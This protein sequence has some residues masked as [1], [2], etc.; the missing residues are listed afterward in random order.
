MVNSLNLF[1]KKIYFQSCKTTGKTPII[2]YEIKEIYVVATRDLAKQFLGQDQTK[3]PTLLSM[4]SD[5]DW[6]I[7]HSTAPY[8]VRE[9]LDADQDLLI[10]RLTVSHGFTDGS[11]YEDY[12]YAILLKNNFAKSPRE[13]Q[14]KK[15]NWVINWQPN[16]IKSLQESLTIQWQKK[17]N[18]LVDKFGAVAVSEL[19]SGEVKEVK[20]LT[21]ERQ[22]TDSELASMTIEE[23]ISFL[24][25]WEPDSRDCLEE[26]SRQLLGSALAKLAEKNLQRYAQ[27]SAHFTDL[28]PIYLFNLLKGLRQGLNNQQGQQR[29][30]GQFSWKS[31][32]SLCS[33]LAQNSQTTD[34]DWRESCRAVLDLLELGLTDEQIGIPLQLREEVW[35]TIKLLNQA[36][37]PTPKISIHHPCELA[38]NTVNDQGEAMHTVIRYALWIRRHWELTS[39]GAG[40]LERGF[41]EMPE[42]RQVLDEH[43]R[44]EQESSLAI[45]SV[46]GQWFP[47]LILLDLHWASENVEKIFPQAQTLSNLRF[48]AWESYVSFSR[49]NDKCFDLL[50]AEYR[51]TI[52]GLNGKQQLTKS[53]E[54]LA[55]HLMALYWRG[56]LDL[57]EPGGL[58]AQF[59]DLAPSALRGYALQIV[60]RSLQ[61]TQNAIPTASS[62]KV[63]Q[64]LKRLQLLW[65]SRLEIARNST[66]PSLYATELA[67]FGWWF[68]SGK[69]D[70]SWAIAQIKLVLEVVD[71]VDSDFLVLERL[72]TLADVL[73]ESAVECLKLMINKD[74]K[75][76]GIYSWHDEIK[77][78]LA[79]A[80]Q[81]SND[82]AKQTAKALIHRLAERGHWEFRDLLSASSK[83]Y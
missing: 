5:W 12:K 36:Q 67:A 49:V 30:Q 59:F 66:E 62:A 79:K 71:Q 24:K 47:S 14:E 75:G 40:Q 11:D 63:P 76:W 44:P 27:A 53:D 73:P 64:I 52:E 39:E 43:L 7:F 58:L 45:H 51:H 42:V 9:F 61:H 46:Y 2:Q 32:L 74:H 26:S 83:R 80:I 29:E 54:S 60:G 57:H 35:Y 19:I 23:L 50:Q 37:E 55:Q 77:T 25:R 15:V 34:N 72:A 22:K 41:E 69:F 82:T 38:I 28:H 20:L 18:R 65:E 33:W 21:V 48:A 56:K 6:Q 68:G 81:G 78:I 10:A 8:P 1:Q 13:A 3:I 4:L 70:N 16:Q 31:V 17:Y